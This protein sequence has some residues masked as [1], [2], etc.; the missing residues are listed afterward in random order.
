MTDVTNWMWGYTRKA[1]TTCRWPP[2]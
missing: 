2:Y 1:K